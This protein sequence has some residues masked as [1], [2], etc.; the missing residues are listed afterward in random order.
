M[1]EFRQGLREVHQ[2]ED[3]I[4]QKETFK[5]PSRL[6]LQYRQS[7]LYQRIIDD[8]PNRVASGVPE[9]I[10]AELKALRDGQ[11]RTAQQNQGPPG[12]P[13]PGGPPGAPGAP[14]NP[15]NPGPPGPSQPP[16][17]PPSGPGPSAPS[18]PGPRGP[19]PGVDLTPPRPTKRG[20]DG[21][22]AHTDEPMTDSASSGSGGPPPP[23]GAGA[24]SSFS[25]GSREVPISGPGNHHHYHYT[26]PVSGGPPP[27]AG[28]AMARDLAAHALDTARA[29]REQ[30][31]SF[32]TEMSERYA[33]QEK[34]RALL[35]EHA[36]SLAGDVSITR[37]LAE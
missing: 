26:N 2:W 1:P 13:G 3:V 31:A 6:S 32:L 8:L 18:T 35:A 25:S 21:G 9:T 20:G 7:L 15:G 11:E 23:P 16:A 14:G 36:Q 29:L 19:G 37:A 34:R 28:I 24:V 17:P 30:Q 5:L 22:T 33:A 27:D 12:P 10:T 4:K